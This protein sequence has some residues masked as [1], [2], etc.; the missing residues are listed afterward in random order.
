M[1]GKIIAGIGLALAM[2]GT[3]MLARS[4][5]SGYSIPF[6]DDHAGTG[7]SALRQTNDKLKRGQQRAMWCIFAGFAFQLA[8]LFF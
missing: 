3:F 7:G 6:W 2:Y 5:P 8:S 1:S 4:T